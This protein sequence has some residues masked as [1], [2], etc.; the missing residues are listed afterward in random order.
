ME[1]SEDPVQYALFTADRSESI[2]QTTFA[3]L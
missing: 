1:F 2:I 3:L